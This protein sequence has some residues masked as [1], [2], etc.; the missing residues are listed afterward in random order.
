M[1]IQLITKQEAAS[2][3]GISTFTLAA[4]RYQKKLIEGIH[5]QCLNSRNVRY[6]RESI[7]H[8]A[9]HFHN[10]EAHQRYCNERIKQINNAS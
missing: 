1:T 3:L 2:I 5:Y 9:N 10:P 7:I 6:V 4:W 8:M